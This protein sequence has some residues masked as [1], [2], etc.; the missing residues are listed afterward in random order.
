MEYVGLEKMT[1]S[2]FDKIIFDSDEDEIWKWWGYKW[3]FYWKWFQSDDSEVS[4][5]WSTTVNNT[6]SV[7]SV[8]NCEQS[9]PNNISNSM[10]IWE[11]DPQNLKK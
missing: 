8:N 5:V 4:S 3:G 9:D 11:D 6:V 2:D 1:R 10:V 7:I